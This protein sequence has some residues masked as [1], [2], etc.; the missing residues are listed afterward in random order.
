[1]DQVSGDGVPWGSK[2]L[3]PGRVSAVFPLSDVADDAG[4]S[5]IRLDF[6]KCR[7]TT[8]GHVSGRSHPGTVEAS[9]PVDPVV[10]AASTVAANNPEQV[11]LGIITSLGLMDRT[12]KRFTMLESSD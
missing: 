3:R 12:R 1:M 9:A 6:G 5:R 8:A 11:K 4:G 10:A 2:L 7:K